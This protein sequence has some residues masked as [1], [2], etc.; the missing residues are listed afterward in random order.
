MAA[1]F[2]LFAIMAGL[3]GL[4]FFCG[5][6]DQEAEPWQLIFRAGMA[7]FCAFACGSCLGIACDAVGGPTGRASRLRS[8]QMSSVSFRPP[9]DGKVLTGRYAGPKRAQKSAH[10]R[11]NGGYFSASFTQLTRVEFIFIS[12]Q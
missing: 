1:T 4:T 11:T 10:S 6:D 12:N 5:T 8:A 2:L 7:I 9:F 3:Y